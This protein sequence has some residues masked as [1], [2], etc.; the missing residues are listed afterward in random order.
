MKPDRG[1]QAWR[2]SNGMRSSGVPIFRKCIKKAEHPRNL[3]EVNAANL[4]R[5]NLSIGE[6]KIRLIIFNF[7]IST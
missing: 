5:A 2:K 4:G 7:I 3:M 6:I 1:K